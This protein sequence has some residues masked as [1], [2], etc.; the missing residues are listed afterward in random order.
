[1]SESIFGRHMTNA[2]GGIIR[3]FYNGVTRREEAWVDRVVEGREH[4]SW[5]IYF[6]WDIRDNGQLTAANKFRS[7]DAALTDYDRRVSELQGLANYS[8]NPNSS[9]SE[10]EV[11]DG[12][13]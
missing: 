13:G 9:A 12:R 11:P 5:T 8:G 10:S 4:A 3:Q 6:V 2:D 1:M 7:H